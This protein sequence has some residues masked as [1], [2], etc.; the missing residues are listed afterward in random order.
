MANKPDSVSDSVKLF[1]QECVDERIGREI[2]RNH[3]RLQLTVA[4]ISVGVAVLAAVI[5]FTLNLMQAN[6]VA[7]LRNEIRAELQGVA[8]RVTTVEQ[9]LPLPETNITLPLNGATVGTTFDFQVRFGNPRPGKYYYLMNRIEG[10]Y[11]PKVLLNVPQRGGVVS[12]RSNEGGNPRN[13]M[14]FEVVVMEVDES[15]HLRISK[16]L[17]GT[18]FPGLQVSGIELG[19]VAVVLRR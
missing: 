13:G 17:E 10:Q 19:R 12:G 1:V 11:W 16:W 2:E 14:L 8:K 9:S 18:T 4:G 3:R 6:A 7:Q 15:E 5:G